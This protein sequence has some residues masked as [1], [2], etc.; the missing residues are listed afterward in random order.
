MIIKKTITSKDFGALSKQAQILFSRVA[1]RLHPKFGQG[2]VSS[3]AAKFMNFSDWMTST[4]LSDDLK[5]YQLPL[6]LGVQ[7]SY[8]DYEGLQATKQS[9]KVID[10]VLASVVREMN[11]KELDQ[12]SFANDGNTS[13]P[14]PTKTTTTEETKDPFW[15]SSSVLAAGAFPLGILIKRSMESEEEKK[16][17]EKKGG[18]L[19]S[20]IGAGLA[21]SGIGYALG[22]SDAAK[23]AVKPIVNNLNGV[24]TADQQQPQQSNS[25]KPVDQSEISSMKYMG[26]KHPYLLAGTS[27]LAGAGV[28]GGGTAVAWAFDSATEKL[29]PKPK[30]KTAGRTPRKTKSTTPDGAKVNDKAIPVEDVSTKNVNGVKRS[31]QAQ[32]FIEDIDLKKKYPNY[33]MKCHFNNPEINV[34]GGF[35]SRLLDGA[36]DFNRGLGR[37]F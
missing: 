32:S 21:A 17:R 36:T 24:K 19:I 3:D 35:L 20:D 33:E 27:A 18:D 5:R 25:N 4:G 37:R 9:N 11:H 23:D 8:P 12:V 34:K 16:R 7:H 6:P 29:G 31:P 22:T 14:S 15:T 2:V 10:E 30:A 26:E 28:A 1:E 13:T